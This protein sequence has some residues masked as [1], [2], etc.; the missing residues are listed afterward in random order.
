MFEIP[1]DRLPPG[2]A[3]RIAEPPIEAATPRPAATAVLLRD[4]AAGPEALLMR[5]HRES[6]FVP[7]AYVYPGGRVDEDDG[8]PD[9]LAYVKG[10]L[11]AEPE[12]SFWLAAVR[13]V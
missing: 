9:L 12:S 8:H 4:S 5:R 11:P 1:A 7:G 13:E 10:N 2:F 3:E 6:G